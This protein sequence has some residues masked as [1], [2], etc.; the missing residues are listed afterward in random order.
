MEMFDL[1]DIIELNEF[2]GNF[3]DY[4]EAVY[5]IFKKD[6]VD[7]KPIYRGTK[8][9]LKWHPEFQGRAYTFYHMTHFGN[10]EDERIPDFRRMERI[11][12]PKP[13]IDDSQHQYLKVWRNIRRGLGGTK[14]RIL[15]LHEEEGYLVVLDDRGDYILPW[16]A[17]YLRSPKEVGKK[18]KEYE[19]YIKAENAKKS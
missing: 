2:G 1:P 15:I 18:L 7:S 17:Y 13:I 5:E 4:C 14:E 9:R 16:T 11:A 3:E 8:L 12:W 10:V 19:D 6:F